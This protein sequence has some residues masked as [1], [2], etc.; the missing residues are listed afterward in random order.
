MYRFIATLPALALSVACSQDYADPSMEDGPSTIQ[1]EDDAADS[2][3]G[4]SFETPSKDDTVDG[5]TGGGPGEGL[6]PDPEIGSGDVA[7]EPSEYPGMPGFEPPLGWQ[8]ANLPAGSY[9]MQYGD[10]M[11][12]PTA[13]FPIQPGHREVVLAP[14]I[15]GFA[16]LFGTA[17]ILTD[18]NSLIADGFRLSPMEGGDCE[19]VHT[20]EAD[21]WHTSDTSFDM[22]IIETWEM[23]GVD[24][25]TMEKGA[26]YTE[27]FEYLASFEWMAPE[28]P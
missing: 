14:E 1:F 17:P 27:V 5:S 23:S 6:V 24:C 15:D 9:W 3:D 20:V 21:G 12:Q 25:E 2:Q 10:V 4:F 11:A 22:H 18:L 28:G 8:R 16:Y 7:D 13:D 19:L 26:P